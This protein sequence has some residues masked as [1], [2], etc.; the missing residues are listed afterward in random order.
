MEEVKMTIRR[1]LAFPAKIVQTDIGDIRD[2]NVFWAFRNDESDNGG[3][4]LDQEIVRRWPALCVEEMRG[5]GIDEL[6][7]SRTQCPIFRRSLL[8]DMVDAY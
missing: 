6:A 3:A 4:H 5:S 1:L 7:G 2:E 8:G